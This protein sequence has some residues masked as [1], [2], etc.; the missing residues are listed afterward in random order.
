MAV[1][2]RIQAYATVAAPGPIK[3]VDSNG[4]LLVLLKKLVQFGALHLMKSS[5][6]S[7]LIVKLPQFRGLSATKHLCRGFAKQ[8]FA[9]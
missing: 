3:S 9:D 6:E 7:I 2:R 5:R 8:L 4:W 1:L